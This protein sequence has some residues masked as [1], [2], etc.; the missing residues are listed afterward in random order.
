MR[1]VTVIGVGALAALGGLV[2]A[3]V[4][5]R[6]LSLGGGAA[7]DA[8]RN[9]ATLDEVQARTVAVPQARY[10]AEVRVE[11]APGETLVISERG[12]FDRATG[13]AW[14]ETS[15][16]GP[17]HHPGGPEPQVTERL[18]LTPDALYLQP[19]QAAPALGLPPTA[20]L[21]TPL[22]GTGVAAAAH[23]LAHDLAGFGHDLAA[24]ASRSHPADVHVVGPE[25]VRGAQTTRLTVTNGD[26]GQNG[27]NA[28][29][30]AADVW[31]DRR[32]RLRRLQI[33]RG[34]ITRRLEVVAYGEPVTVDIPDDAQTATNNAAV[35]RHALASLRDRG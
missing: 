10:A 31:I 26:N 30:A 12:A 1:R 18:R 4:M 22:D 6:L 25:R 32:G 9:P 24:L 29:A 15:V 33:V 23:D 5:I 13:H 7:P 20:W 27:H 3:V 17:S 34:P 16:S 19:V 8:D 14:A 28:N 35:V 21:G 2:A 11:A